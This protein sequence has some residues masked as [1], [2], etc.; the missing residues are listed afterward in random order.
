MFGLALQGIA[1]VWEKTMCGL[2]S[3][4]NR[5]RKESIPAQ[6]WKGRHR[7]IHGWRIYITHTMKNRF[8][9]PV[10]PLILAWRCRTTKLLT[11]ST[12]VE[13]LSTNMLV[14]SPPQEAILKPLEPGVPMAMA[15]VRYI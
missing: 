9:W 12:A 10:S 5:A 6:A 13:K 3:N 8:L 15:L 7:I 14:P 1:V 2:G 4:C 11:K